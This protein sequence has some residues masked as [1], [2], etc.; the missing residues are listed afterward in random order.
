MDQILASSLTRQI[1]ARFKNYKTISVLHTWRENCFVKKEKKKKKKKASENTASAP[2]F[3][4]AVSE[5]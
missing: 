2:G 1:M 3:P 5:I 4:P